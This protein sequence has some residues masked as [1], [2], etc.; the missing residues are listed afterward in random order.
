MEWQQVL[1]LLLVDFD[2]FVSGTWA[3]VSYFDTMTNGLFQQE[4]G[5]RGLVRTEFII[6]TV[7]QLAFFVTHA[8]EQG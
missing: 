1:S 8:L 2:V 7:K 6:S 4:Y 5:S 3:Y